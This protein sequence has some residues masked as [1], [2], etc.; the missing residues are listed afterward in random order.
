[1]NLNKNNS[2]YDIVFLSLARNCEKTIHKFFNFLE[3]LK[4]NDFKV[5]SIVGENNSEDL[6]FDK[7]RRYSENSDLVK[8]LDTTFIEKFD[9]RILRLSKAR[10][11]LKNFIHEQNITSKYICVIDLDEVIEVGISYQKFISLKQML[12][13]NN[14][15]F[16][17]ISVKTT[18]YYYDILNYEDQ[19]N[20]NLDILKLQNRKDLF[21]YF[22]RKKKI[23]NLQK[24][25]SEKDDLISISSFNGLC[26]YFFKDFINGYYYQES[27]NNPIP[28]HLNLNRLIKKK[29]NK[30][31][32]VSNQLILRMPEEH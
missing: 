29:T 20:I 10:Q 6:T 31:I 25:I 11:H 18:P 22:E 5:L 27:N 24:R 17:A 15:K 3:E 26:I 16:F 19:N 28:E 32:L 8:L 9:D 7:I 13:K 12:D 1:M 21:S 14:D 4:K 23:Y 30:D 2:D